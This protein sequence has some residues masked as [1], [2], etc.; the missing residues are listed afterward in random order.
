MVLPVLVT[1]TLALVW[2][3][4]GRVRTDSVRGPPGPARTR[5]DPQGAAV[6]S[7][8]RAAPR[9]AKVAVSR[10]GDL[11]RVAVEAAAPVRAC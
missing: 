7:A 5:Q 9:D 4:D 11:V 10:E 2:A 3:L 6:E 8:K 1:C